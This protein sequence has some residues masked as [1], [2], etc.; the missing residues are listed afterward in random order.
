MQIVSCHIGIVKTNLQRPG[1]LDAL[2]VRG[3]KK[4]VVRIVYL[5]CATWSLLCVFLFTALQVRGMT[6]TVLTSVCWRLSN[7]KMILIARSPMS[8][9]RQISVTQFAKG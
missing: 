6:T 7:A 3:E 4:P 2:L 5:R 9:F 8:S 1:D